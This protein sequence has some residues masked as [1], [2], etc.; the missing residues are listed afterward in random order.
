MTIGKDAV[1][2]S[3]YLVT[4]SGLLSSSAKSFEDHIEQLIEGG[5]TIV[6]LREKSLST[7]DFVKRAKRLLEVTQPR[8]IPLVINDRVDVA[9]AVDADGVHVGQDDMGCLLHFNRQSKTLDVK[10][11]RRL[12][13]K[14]KIVGV[15]VNTRTEAETA[16]RDGADY[17]GNILSSLAS[18]AHG[19]GIGA[20]FDTSTKSLTTLPCGIKGVREILKTVSLQASR[21]K[22]VAIGGLN[23]NNIARMRYQSETPSS[24]SKLDG[25]A[26]V[27]ALMAADNPREAASQLKKIFQETP[28]FVHKQNWAPQGDL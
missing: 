27:S 22:T 17:L 24:G 5:V 13:G 15:S 20:I 25:V 8:K 21:V 23:A 12:L 6:Q 19:S 28:T 18:F 1:D 26:V 7:A 3:L 16:I 11:V 9:L 10:T 14:D 4:G 2:Y